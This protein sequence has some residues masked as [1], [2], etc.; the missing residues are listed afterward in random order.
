MTSSNPTA[1]AAV[2]FDMD[3]V[4]IDSEP[5][6]QEVIEEV[7]AELGMSLTPEMRAHTMGMGNHESVHYVLSLHPGVKADVVAVSRKINDRMLGRIGAGLG[8]IPGSA[9]LV[10]ELAGRGVPLALVSTSA[11]ALMQAVIRAHRF[12]GLFRLVLSA[13]VVGPSKPDPAVY[14]E[15]VRRLQAEPSRSVAIEGM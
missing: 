9:E 10:C 4:L 12:E 14:R 13:E 15:A 7:Y 6:W 3:G 11:S 1:C 2:F 5:V 8:G